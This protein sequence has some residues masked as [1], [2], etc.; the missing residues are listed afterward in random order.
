MTTLQQ[1][2]PTAGHT[3]KPPVKITKTAVL[4]AMLE[5]RKAYLCLRSDDD[6]NEAIDEYNSFVM[7][8]GLI[9]R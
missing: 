6:N 4:A 1:N 3:E 5:Q 2:K 8:S 9:I 7:S